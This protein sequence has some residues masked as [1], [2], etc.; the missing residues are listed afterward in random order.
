MI[1]LSRIWKLY[2][3]YTIVLIGGMTLAGFV[4][5]SQLKSRLIENLYENVLTLARVMGKSVQ[6]LQNGSS[7][8]SFCKEYAETSGVRITIMDKEGR[9]LADSTKEAVT[10]DDRANRPEVLE[11][12]QRGIGISTRYSETLNIEM[13]YAALVLEEK[14]KILRLAVPMTKIKVFENEVMIIFAL[15]LYLA[16]LFAMIIAFFFTKY[17]SDEEERRHGERGAR[18]L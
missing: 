17:R 18:R 6:G 1:R 4:L 9:V 12:Q 8:D 3:V 13:L 7:L 11:A 10:G 5:R 2:L 14:G 16:P 15:A